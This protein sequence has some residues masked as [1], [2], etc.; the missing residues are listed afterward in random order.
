MCL[1]GS[2][3]TQVRS[4]WKCGDVF[5][6]SQKMALRVLIVRFPGMYQCLTRKDYVHPA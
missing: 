4:D 2:I 1:R 3:E 5:I 6:R